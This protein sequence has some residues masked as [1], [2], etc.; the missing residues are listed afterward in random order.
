LPFALKT[1]ALFTFT[2]AFCLLSASWRIDFVRAVT[3]QSDQSGASRGSAQSSLNAGLV[4]YWTFN[5]QDMNWKTGAVNDISGSGNTGQLIG[6]STT[7]SPVA[8]KMGQALKFNGVNNYVGMTSA[9]IPSSIFTIGVWIK[10]TDNNSSYV[11]DIVNQWKSGTDNRFQVGMNYTG[12]KISVYFKGYPYLTGKTVVNDGKWHHVVLTR[13][14]SNLMTIYTDGSYEVSSTISTTTEQGAN[15]LIGIYSSSGS[16][17]WWNGSLDDVRIYNRALS[18]AEVKQLYLA[19]QVTLQSDQSGATRG[20]AIGSLNCG[21]VGYW[22]FNNQDMNWKTGQAADSSGKGNT[23][24]L[25]GMSTTTSPVPGKL[26]QGLGFNGSTGYVALQSTIPSY[27]TIS[28]WFKLNNISQNHQ[29]LFTSITGNGTSAQFDSGADGIYLTIPGNSSACFYSTNGSGGTILS[30]IL[31]NRWYHL[32]IVLGSNQSVV[33]ANGAVST[34]TLLGNCIP[35]SGSNIASL[36]VGF[37]TG[38]YLNGAEDDV[39]IYNRALSASEVKQLYLAGQV[40]LQS[41]QSGATRGCAIG[42]LNCGLVGYW[43]F[44]NQDMNWK[45]GQARDVS[46]NGNTGQLI[47]MSTTTSPVAGK[48]GQGLK[49]NGTSQYVNVGN[50]IDAPSAI[51][52]SFWLKA[53]SITTG[54]KEMIGKGTNGQNGYRFLLTAGGQPFFQGKT[55]GGSTLFSASS[56]SNIVLNQWIH[57]VGTYDGTTAK[58]YVNGTLNRSDPW[59]SGA[60]TSNANPLGIGASVAGPDGFF[61]GSLDDVRIYNRALTASEVKQLYM[62]GM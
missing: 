18:A 26:G 43:T 1:F 62:S 57:Y 17:E 31:A 27:K 9:L 11:K 47:G 30:N 53:S 15:T 58:I 2:F 39:R 8:G 42:S 35:S 20:C 61:P 34:T 22:T 10:T 50:P 41:D 29:G 28:L 44:N 51:T 24:Q 23:G 5:N 36:G 45:T 54:T 37:N 59:A 21:L 55:T 7:T 3:L 12:K 33:Y 56:T 13:N 40:T 6:M 49:F 14:A 4:G 52:I 46:G 19:G 60:I 32:A 38:F 16:G 25:I 48:M